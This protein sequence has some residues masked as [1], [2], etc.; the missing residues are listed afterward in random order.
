MPNNPSTSPY[1]FLI[2]RSQSKDVYRL[3]RVDP[4]AEQL[5]TPVSPDTPATFDHS[6]RIA[7]VGGYLLQWS[8]LCE[9][10]GEP[11]FNFKLLDFNPEA[12][13]PL[14]APVVQS[15]FW[16]KKKFWGYRAY[17]SDNPDEDQHLDLIPMASF[18]LSLIPAKGRGTFELW[19][20]DPQWDP[21]PATPGNADPL[22]YPYTGQGGFPL[23]KQGHTLIPI[24]NYVLDR[25]PDRKQFRLWSFDPQQH[26]PLS[27]PAVQEGCWDKIDE[28]SELT[29]LGAQVLE[30]NAAQGRYRLWAFDPEHK[31][32]LVGPLREGE[33]PSDIGADAVLTGYQP[34]IPVQAD[35]AQTPGTIDFMRS[36]IKHVVYYMVESR[37]FDNVCGW[38]YEKGDQG[39]HYIGSHE[40]FDG[41]STENFNFDGEKKVHVSKFQGGKLS[42]Q[43]DLIALNQ[44]PFHDTTDSLQQMF[45]ESPGY[46]GRLQPDMGGFILNNANPQVMETFSPEQLPVLNGLARSFAISDRWFSSVPGGTDINRAFSVTG[47][48]FDKLGTWEGGNAYKYWPDSPHRQSIWKVLWS[49]GISDW[50][51]Y[52]SIKWLDEVFT[53]QLYLKG[54]IPTVD[55]N[56]DKYLAD[57]EQFKQDAAAGTL[58]AF[59]FLEPVWIAPSGATSY[60]PGADLVPAEKALNDIYEAIKNG[61]GWD[62]T[63]LVITFDKNNGIYDHVAPPYARKPW[64]HDINDGFAY[65]LMGPRVP[66]IM[67]SP[68]IK[69]QTVFRAE[70]EIPFDSTSFAATLLHWFGVPKSLW[71][72][73]DRMEVAP[74]FE[75]VLQATESRSDAPTLTPPYDKSFPSAGE[76]TGK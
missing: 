74:T 1:V 46:W 57:I 29:A 33:L 31:D 72:L 63:L 68:W 32:V 28:S 47:S 53:Y 75:A 59:S 64:P 45:A 41:A 49:Q 36:K 15:G 70:G 22:P 40:P 24:G 17:Y 11:G 5:L 21:K 14:N 54:Q 27:L 6:Y 67:V 18:V 4:D 50:K 37:S 52:D 42:D 48:A 62:E 71:A 43:Y 10:G 35:K 13:D 25:L 34:R 19:N 58:P 55:A 66:T 65:D 69:Q 2:C 20:F 39:C 23:I 76:A 12:A 30:W 7:Q 8:P 51:I 60:H 26:P 73:G 16:E 56:A 44:D 61:P 9:Q 3:Y 38:L